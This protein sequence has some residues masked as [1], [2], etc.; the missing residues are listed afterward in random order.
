MNDFSIILFF[1][2]FI[3]PFIFLW[4]IKNLVVSAIKEIK[5]ETKKN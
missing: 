5:N 2:F 3:G 1:V 4:F